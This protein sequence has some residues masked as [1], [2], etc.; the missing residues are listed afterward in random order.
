LLGVGNSAPALHTK[1]LMPYIS[2]A[3]NTFLSLA[4]SG[5]LNAFNSEAIFDRK[6]VLACSS[7]LSIFQETDDPGTFC[8]R[9]VKDDKREVKDM[10]YNLTVG[11]M[12]YAG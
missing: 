1:M 2:A 10:S 6:T 3:I 9:S 5:L 12:V 11:C 8:I 7:S 4:L